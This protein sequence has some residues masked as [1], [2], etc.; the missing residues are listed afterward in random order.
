[1]AIGL[2]PAT[3]DE[4]RWRFTSDDAQGYEDYLAAWPKGRHSAEA[5]SRYDEIRDISGFNYAL[6]LA[7]TDGYRAY[8]AR[9]PNGR[10]R[11]D[12]RYLA[13]WP[14]A[15]SRIGGHW[16]EAAAWQLS[17]NVNTLRSLRAYAEAYPK[18]PFCSRAESRIEELT[19]QQ[20]TNANTIRALRAY[21]QAYPKG[22]SYS[23]AK[24]G[25]EDLT[26]QQATNANTIRALRA[27]SQAYPKG[28]FFAQA[29]L[30]QAVLRTNE[31]PYSLALRAGTADALNRFLQDFPGHIKEADAREVLEDMTEGRDIVDLINQKKIDVQSQGGGIQNVTVQIKSLMPYPVMVRI[32]VGTFFVSSSESAQNMVTTTESEVLLSSHASQYVSVDTACANRPRNVPGHSDQFSVQ[33]SPNQKQLEAL[34]PALD[35]AQVDYETRQAAVWIVTDDANYDDLGELVD[36]YNARVIHETEAA[37]AMKICAEAGIDIT[38]KRIWADKQTILNGLHDADLKKWLKQKQ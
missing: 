10:F 3:R 32:P 33:R 16:T 38:Q 4:L 17:T 25:I 6:S 20:A 22:R 34:M 15:L 8:L 19:W 5:R 13:A 37:R 11:A 23:R 35:K 21:S 1:M 36:S 28:R 30:R 24:S 29:E 9:W 31:A 18:G 26:W 14:E 7:R 27:Y 2:F 12:A